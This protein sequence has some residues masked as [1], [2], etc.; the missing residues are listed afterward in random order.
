[1]KKIIESIQS[2]GIAGTFPSDMVL[3]GNGKT[4]KALEGRIDGGIACPLMQKVDGHFTSPLCPSCYAVS[5]LNNYPGV[6]NL[7]A[8]QNHS[9][10][11]IIMRAAG[12]EAKS[13]TG[14]PI[15]PGDRLRIYGLTDFRPA[16]LNILKLL[17]KVY[18]LDI[19]SKTLW[20]FKP[21]RM[22]LPELA[23]LPGI[24]ISLS[25]NK[26]DRLAEIGGFES[27]EESIAACRIFIRQNKLQKSTSLNYTFTTKWR[28]EATSEMEPYRR[29]PGVRVYHTVSKDKG[30]LAAA[31]GI[32]GV[33][34]MFDEIGRPITDF[35]KA[36]GSCLGCNFCR[37]GTAA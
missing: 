20:H 10:Q 7:L 24:C 32:K 19:I 3:V 37:K 17:S 27:I 31:I 25:F 2:L 21:C 6:R 18:K 9:A 30:A 15:Y 23:R 36:K 34:G 1:M 4:G 35:K 14:V 8:T 33:C 12:I 16:H 28:E 13:T 29:I 22:L 5:V 11:E 26:K